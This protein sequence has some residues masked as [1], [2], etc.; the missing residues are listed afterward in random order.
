MAR[1]QEIDG[2]LGK[3]E[4]SGHG[5]TVPQRRPRVKG[6]TRQSRDVGSVS[7]VTDVGGVAGSGASPQTGRMPKPRRL[8]PPLLSGLT[9]GLLAA[10]AC[11]GSPPS[12]SSTP[13]SASSLAPSSPATSSASTATASPATPGS[14]TSGSATSGATTPTATSPVEVATGLDV[15]WGLAFLPDGSALVTLRDEGR[16]LRVR[17]G[18]QP[19]EVGRIDGVEAN[20]EGGLLGIAVS[21]E[22][23]TDR[24]VFVYH[25]TGEDNRVARLRL[26]GDRLVPERVILSGIPSGGIHN[27]GRIKVGPD[28]MLW[29]PTGDASERDQAPDPSSLGGKILRV[30]ADGAPAPGNPDASSPVWSRGHRNVQGL[31]W[32]REQR[33]WATEFGQNTW[34]E[35][36]LIEK[37]RDYGWPTVEGRG[38]GT[39]G[40][41]DA[42]YTDPLVVWST[43]QA[44]PSGLAIGADGAAYVAAL[45]GE[46]LW[47]VPLRGSTTG[48]PQALL[49]GTYGRLRTVERGP[50]GRLWIITSNTFRGD[51]RDGDDRIVILPASTGR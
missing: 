49:Q 4:D 35:L 29:V 26:E 10:T 17:E 18:A 7:H 5:S 13:S 40:G 19:V 37:G 28:G 34:D 20:G 24:R 50:D 25:T 45:M 2:A 16:V 21:R 46:R 23:A 15:P 42:R 30:T 43:D 31:A 27:G 44:S 51:E 3:Y 33:L 22:F 8:A 6:G 47:R 38:Q 11:T 32:D 48:E 12:P 39:A 14:A 9:A 1:C 41:G 36:N